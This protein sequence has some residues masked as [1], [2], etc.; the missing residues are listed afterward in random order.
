MSARREIE[1]RLGSL[2]EI[3][4]VMNA[5][6]TLAYMETRKLARFIAIQQ[7][8]V[9]AIEAM[10]ADLL[11]H[12]PDVRPVSAPAGRGLILIGAERGFC[13]DFNGRVARAARES[14]R[15][16]ASGAIIAVGRRLEARLEEGD[17]PMVILD[18]ASAAEQVAGVLEELAG[19][20]AR[21]QQEHGPLALRAVYHGGEKGDLLARGLLP[22]FERVCAAQRYR[23]APQIHLSPSALFAALLD[24]YLYAALN[25]MLCTSLMAENQARMQHLDSAMRH[26]DERRDEFARRGRALRQEEIIEEIEVILLNVAPIRQASA[27]VGSAPPA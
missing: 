8:Q 5:M 7:R 15:S 19:S 9:A 24:E 18:G 22:R 21:L 26:L 20:I 13:G 6:K 17:T 10:A 2:A 16:A 12:H 3:R 25:A 11:C 23:C 27:G 14:G 4:D 1:R